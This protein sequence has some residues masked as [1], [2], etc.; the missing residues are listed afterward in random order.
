MNI[1]LHFLNN[2]IRDL[3]SFFLYSVDTPTEKRVRKWELSLED[4]ALDPLGSYI[5]GFN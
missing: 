5:I 3:L 2:T 4:L 1:R